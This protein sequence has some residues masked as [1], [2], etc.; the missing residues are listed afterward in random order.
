MPNICLL[1]INLQK[2]FQIIF[3]NLSM[4]RQVQ[5]MLIISVMVFVYLIL[6]GIDVVILI[7]LFLLSFIFTL[8]ALKSLKTY[9]TCDCLVQNMDWSFQK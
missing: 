8:S 9:Y 2:Y 3:S 1:K 7:R 5:T 6:I 4:I